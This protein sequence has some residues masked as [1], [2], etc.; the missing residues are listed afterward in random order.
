MGQAKDDISKLLVGPRGRL[1]ELFRLFRIGAEFLRGFRALHFLG[2]CVTVFGS[3]RIKDGDAE[4]QLA[5]QVGGLAAKAGFI[6]M[7][8]GGP[9]IMEASA[10]GAQE[11]GGYTV[12]CNIEL[13]H[14]QDA[15]P[16]LN[17]V[18]TFRYFFVR[19]VMLLKYSQ[20]V[21]VFPGGFGT[22]DELFEVL[23]LIQTRKVTSC[24]VVLVG[25]DFW[26]PLVELIEQRLLTRGLISPGDERI[27][28]V[29]D[30]V[31]EVQQVLES[32]SKLQWKAGTPHWWLL[33][34]CKDT[35]TTPNS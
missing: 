25:R 10:R 8:G 13:P 35:A 6:V 29:T 5:R 22:L 21:I 34:C 31:E 9:G 15:N 7:T 24:P 14:E 2:P 18:V 11:A 30:Y 1:E 32:I 26:A 16:Y 23:T 4:Y 19:K 28:R 12:G 20:A 33:E 27:F 3:A 17:R